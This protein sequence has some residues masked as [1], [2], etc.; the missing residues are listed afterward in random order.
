MNLKHKK[1]LSD[2]DIERLIINDFKSFLKERPGV[3][4]FPGDVL[5]LYF[6]YRIA[7]KAPK[8]LKKSI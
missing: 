3:L 5:N 6:N 7:N 2:K 1:T 8:K 4:L